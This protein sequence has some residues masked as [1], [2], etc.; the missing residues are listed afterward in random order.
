M[1]PEEHDRLVD[2]LVSRLGER[3][4][5]ERARIL[6]DVRQQ[7]PA[8]A[9]A[10][11]S[12]VA[13][14]L[15]EGTTDFDREIFRPSVAL[16]ADLMGPGAALPR[17]FG[18]YDLGPL[19]G[20]GGTGPVYEATQRSLGRP[21]ALKVIPSGQFITSGGMER[22]RHEGRMMARLTHDH[23]VRVYEVGHVGDWTYL[24]MERIAGQDLQKAFDGPAR[25]WKLDELA[26]QRRAARWAL[27]LAEAMQHAHDRGVQH[28][29]LKPSNV[30]VGPLDRPL[31]VDF[32]LAVRL[33]EGGV[34]AGGSPLYMAPEMARAAL[35]SEALRLES[36]TAERALCRL[37][38]YGLGTI[39]YYL[40]AGAAPVEERAEDRG[41]SSADRCERIC[42]RVAAGEIVPLRL[43]NP[44]V[45]R[46]LESICLRCLSREAEGR[47]ESAA[48][49]A[50]DLR[51][52]L[53]HRPTSARPYPPWERAGMW[54]RRNWAGLGVGAL[55]A[56]ALLAGAFAGLSRF[57]EAGAR[58]VAAEALT[59]EAEARAGT[60]EAQ[61]TA[62]KANAL[63]SATRAAAEKE[64]RERAEKDAFQQLVDSARRAAQRGDFRTAE[65]LYARVLANG[66]L[67]GSPAQRRRL[68]V[69]RLGG[70]FVL[71]NRDELAAALARFPRD[72]LGPDEAKVLLYQGDLALSE[73]GGA[74]RGRQLV[75][76]ALARRQL[77]D[78]DTAYAAGLL[79]GRATDAVAWF[80]KALD[81]DPFHQRAHSA[82]LV[83]LLV[84]CDLAEVRRQAGSMKRIFPDDATPYAVEAWTFLLEGD[85]PSCL[86]QVD[87]L[88]PRLG[89]DRW[90][91]SRAFFQQ[92]GD[93]IALAEKVESYDDAL[94]IV[95]R[96]LRMPQIGN[97]L[98]EPFSFNVPTIDRLMQAAESVAAAHATWKFGFRDSA[99][100]RLHEAAENFPEGMLFTLAGTIRLEQ[101][102]RLEKAK[103][104]PE[105]LRAMAE[106]GELWYESARSPT[107]APRS[108]HRYA[109]RFWGGFFDQ[110]LVGLFA[111][112]KVA[113]PFPAR[114]RRWREHLPT[115]LV[116]GRAHP[117]ARASLMASGALKLGPEAARMLLGDWALDEPHN[118]A[119]LR[120]RAW[121]ELR[122][123]QYGAALTCAEAVLKKVKNDPE[124]IKVRIVAREGLA[125]SLR[126]RGEGP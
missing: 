8:V 86:A 111:H 30:L 13:D 90:R 76:Q 32:G 51:N 61:A 50:A 33:A 43:R 5:E 41:L 95:L 69:E 56:L 105:A 24:S 21:V 54:G 6:A 104:Y 70:W 15:G 93:L 17:P 42:R 66:E 44:R 123:G 57:N 83:A 117:K 19:I 81:R 64:K 37:D 27:A 121:M 9:D 82:L 35:A 36:A 12:I 58:A 10:A 80:H 26:G 34:V 109:A 91:R 47:Y 46:T 119:P 114:E 16:A 118:P 96:V 112:Y 120:L 22:L 74:S 77:S 31:L 75:A 89:E 60:A 102:M 3:P 48:A 106:S 20:S 115:L 4:A 40:L 28:L 73:G 113:D 39:L 122:D 126:T 92:L 94:P 98:T 125:K 45:N 107:I 85:L 62:A 65:E 25:P 71:K 110:Q 68:E 1:S 38:V 23:I 116:E 7:W 2:E 108:P 52:W 59:N 72:E 49:L 87:H 67:A 63:A 14:N 100:E 84:R 55:A 97:A 103:K 53:T 18:D 11:G 101:A 79:A 29:D 78:A 88:R 124:M 99:V